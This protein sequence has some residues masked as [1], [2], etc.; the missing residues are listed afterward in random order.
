MIDRLVSLCWTVLGFST[1]KKFDKKVDIFV[2]KIRGRKAWNI[3]VFLRIL[4]K[5]QLSA[6]KYVYTTNY[7]MPH[8]FLQKNTHFCLK[9]VKMQ[10]SHCM[11]P[12]NE[13]VFYT[14]K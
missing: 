13:R 7:L 3:E 1:R 12:C 4:L 6:K 5:S 8:S 14:T 10:F 2:S 11:T 9:L